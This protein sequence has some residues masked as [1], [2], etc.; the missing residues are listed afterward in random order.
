VREISSVRPSRAAAAL[1]T[2]ALAAGGP[3]AQ[4]AGRSVRV[5]GR[6]LD[7]DGR[8]VAGQTVRIFKTRR[9]ITLP[10]FSSGGQVAE[11]AR[12]ATDENGFYEISVAR[13]RSFDDYFLRFY[14]PVGF[15]VVRFALPPD[16]EITSDLKRG[17]TLH[18][19][20]TLSLN[21]DWPEVGR[22]LEELGEDSPKGRILRSLGLPER[23]APGV[24]PDGPREEWWYHSRG[25]VYF[26]RDGRPAGS[27]RFEP[28][29]AAVGPHQD[30]GSSSGGGC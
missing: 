23:E 24:G 17:E 4:A 6:I 19:D 12:A 1:V 22:R 9:G 3:A 7:P 13:D 15:D 10:K 5:Q 2:L 26:F 18:V 21:P 27:R 25:V 11:A 29:P 14:D 16:R 28:V 30:S 8:G 20:L